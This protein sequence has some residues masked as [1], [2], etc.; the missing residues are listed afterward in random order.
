[1]LRNQTRTIKIG[2]AVIGGGSSILVQ[3][4]CDTDTRNIPATVAQI[5]ELEAA[6]CEIV[7]VAIVDMEA[8]EAIGKIKE[9]IQL[10]IV[11]DIHFDYRL[12]LEAIK[13]GVDKL[14]INPGNIGSEERVK[15]V[16]DAAKSQGIPIRIGV[17]GGSLERAILEKYQR[18]S[19]AA[20]VESA[21][22]HVA[23]LQKNAFEDIVVSLKASNVLET[24]EAYRLMSKECDYPLHLGI[25]ESG[26]PNTGIIRSSVG[27]GILLAE[28][29][30]DTI[31]ISL[32]GSPLEEV[33]VAWEI[34]NNLD[35]RRRGARLIS[36]PTCGRRKG[37]VYGIASEVEKLLRSYQ[38]PFLTVAVM[39]CEVNGPAEARD[40]DIGLALGKEKALLFVHGEVKE[41][42]EPSQYLE[43]LEAAI[44][45]Y[46]PK[47]DAK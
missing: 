36:C 45:A 43:R 20:M 46:Q 14:R 11:A 32:S 7:R 17:N 47:C 30:G 18:P 33:R 22:Q 39:G 24:V 12:A 6:G 19:A 37:D 1:M 21:L 29:L 13:Q 2:S 4:M 8:A 35:L 5:H 44:I 38:G 34:L 25:T 15:A 27:L 26:P 16:A 9:Q 41:V 28:G 42:L 31:R 3:S 23:L 40:A 10:P